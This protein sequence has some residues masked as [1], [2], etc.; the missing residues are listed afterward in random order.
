MNVLLEW[1]ASAPEV[2]VSHSQFA[3]FVPRPEDSV[4]LTYFAVR[5]EIISGDLFTYVASSQRAVSIRVS[6]F[7]MEDRTLVFI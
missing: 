6:A 5:E 4:Y 3:R 2:V 1:M 7:A